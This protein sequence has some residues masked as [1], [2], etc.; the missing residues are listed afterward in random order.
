MFGKASLSA[1]IVQL[2]AKLAAE[3]RAT[4]MLIEA[5][6]RAKVG[7]T[8]SDSVEP[9]TYALMVDGSIEEIPHGYMFEPRN[10]WSVKSPPPLGT[11]AVFAR[12]EERLYFDKRV[13]T[14]NFDSLDRVTYRIRGEDTTVTVAFSEVSGGVMRCLTPQGQLEI[15]LQ[16][17]DSTLITI[18]ATGK[19]AVDLW[20]ELCENNVRNA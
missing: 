9:P 14:E 2:E 19:D 3:S 5:T 7:D 8:S 4:R 17:V 20:K 6:H 16:R 18:I 10:R 1:R 13:L 12:G 11:R 15:N